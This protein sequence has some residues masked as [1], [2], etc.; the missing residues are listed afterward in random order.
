MKKI[1]LFIFMFVVLVSNVST[2]EIEDSLNEISAKLKIFKEQN[3]DIPSKVA[4][5]YP[6]GSIYMST[7]ST[8]PGTIFG[9]TWEAFA[10]GRTLIGVA[11]NGTAG[12]T[13][14]SSSVSIST[15]NIPSHTHTYTA[16]GTVSST[17]TG[18][19]VAS[20]ANGNHSHTF[21]FYNSGTEASGYGLVN[22]SHGFG[23]RVYVN[24]QN[25]STT[26][27]TYNTSHTHSVTPVGTV[28][29]TF[30]GTKKASS[31]VGSGTAISVLNPYITV[32]MWKRT[33]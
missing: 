19:S 18:N 24:G 5:R 7:S 9:G 6:V 30:S 20:S 1:V 15:S 33:A 23:G 27:S 3:V 8:N 28:T 10:I 22:K 16:G 11:S 21:Y 32:Y 29:S 4:K 31:S 14:G 17:F 12:S 2:N 25:E 26:T 13:G